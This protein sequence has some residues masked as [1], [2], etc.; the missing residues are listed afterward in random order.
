MKSL[1]DRGNSRATGKPE[2][3][4]KEGRSVP[5][6]ALVLTESINSGMV[7]NRSAKFPTADGRDE[8]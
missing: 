1:A 6:N 4:A 3:A 8:T 5:R 2:V 7:G